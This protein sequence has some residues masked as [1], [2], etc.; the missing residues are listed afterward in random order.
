M[1]KRIIRRSARGFTLLEMMVVLLIIGLL[2]SVAVI[3]I[4]GRGDDARRA[5]TV[6][7]MNVIVSALKQYQLQFGDYPPTLDAL[8]P[9]FLEDKPSDA[10][11][12]PFVYFP[13]TATGATSSRPYTLYS[14][15]KGGEEGNQEDV[16]DYWK[17][18][19]LASGQ[20]PQQ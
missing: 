11:K 8:S 20:T 18:K 14:K 7:S 3:N 6:Q 12:R 19:E 10:W 16:V 17:E 13:N 5:T 1:K 9:K 15:G 4:V 2:M